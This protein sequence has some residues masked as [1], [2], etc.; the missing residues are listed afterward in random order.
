MERDL[1]VIDG[2][3]VF[4]DGVNQLDVAS[5]CNDYNGPENLAADMNGLVNVVGNP[6]RTLS[7]ISSGVDY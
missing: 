3:Y 2:G 1:S 6:T 4:C 7:V 5:L